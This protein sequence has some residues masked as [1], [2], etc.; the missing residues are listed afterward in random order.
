MKALLYEN[1]TEKIWQAAFEVHHYF[2]QGFLEKVYENALAYKLRKYGIDCQLQ[3]P[4]KVY[5]E[6]DVS[7]G[8]YYAD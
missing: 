6:D 4:L 1:L 7:V 8:E 3:V 2:G 5:Y